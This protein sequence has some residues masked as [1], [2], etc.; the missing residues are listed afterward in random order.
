MFD[1][2]Y[3]VAT[4]LENYGFTRT[5]GARHSFKI[6]IGVIVFL[7][8]A[9]LFVGSWLSQVYDEGN[10]I[11]AT[12]TACVG[13]G[14]LYFGTVQWRAAR[15][16]ISLDKFYE[17]LELTNQQF[18]R[19]LGARSLHGDWNID[20]IASEE[21][22]QRVIYVFREL[23]SLEYSIAK[24]RIGFMS[25]ENAYRSLRTFYSRC[26]SSPEFCRLA[27]IY[28]KLN[29]GY[30]DATQK[31]V[32]NVVQDIERMRTGMLLKP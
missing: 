22:Y 24:Y 2:K 23:D 18:D 11:A 29:C 13:L 26:M 3:P 5:F 4:T 9:G 27:E 31:V 32:H 15:N 10:F 14:A 20:G 21:T 19:S 30:D 8:L 17:R 1:G 12:V 28:V 25:P 6:A 7:A 16:E